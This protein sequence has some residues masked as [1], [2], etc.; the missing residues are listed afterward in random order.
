[1]PTHAAA[2][3]DASPGVARIPDNL[4]ALMASPEIRE[5]IALTAPPA[6][7]GSAGARNPVTH[8]VPEPGPKPPSA[9]DQSRDVVERGESHTAPSDAFPQREEL[10]RA[11]VARIAPHLVAAGT[12]LATAELRALAR[13]ESDRDLLLCTLAVA[14]ALAERDEERADADAVRRQAEADCA[15]HV[16]VDDG[17]EVLPGLAPDRRALAILIADG[18]LAASVRRDDLAAIPAGTLLA[19]MQATRERSAR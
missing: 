11:L 4:D 13:I 15:A 3:H 5:L 1:M 12:W 7:E 19:A 14:R 17:S 10:A 9:D 18:S 2:D 6:L 16:G 8:A